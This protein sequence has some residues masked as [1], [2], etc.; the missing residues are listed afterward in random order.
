MMTTLL[1]PKAEVNDTKIQ[2]IKTRPQRLQKCSNYIVLVN[3]QLGRRKR[4]RVSL[5]GS[6]T[7][8]QHTTPKVMVL[9]FDSQ[10]STARSCLHS[11][12]HSIQCMS[13]CGHARFGCIF[14]HEN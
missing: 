12:L 9:V 7:R 2:Y 5:P 1:R 14:S 8:K 4:Q 6:Y 3:R 13:V 11:A 10:L